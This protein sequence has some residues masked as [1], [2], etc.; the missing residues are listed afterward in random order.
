[1][2]GLEFRSPEEYQLAYQM[3][4]E[5]M[6]QVMKYAVQEDIEYDRNQN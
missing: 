4:S 3:L 5:D 6:L 1:M 2:A